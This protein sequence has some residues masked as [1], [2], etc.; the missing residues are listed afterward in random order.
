MILYRDPFEMS[1]FES[2]NSVA[3]FLLLYG[4]SNFVIVTRLFA[5]NWQGAGEIESTAQALPR[6]FFPFLLGC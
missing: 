6:V 1:R 5:S 2:F 4:I 3:V